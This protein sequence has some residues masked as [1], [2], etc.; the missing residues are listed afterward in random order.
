MDS[1][2]MNKV[3]GA[4]LG[5]C[6]FLVALNI[7]AGAVFTPVKMAKPGYEIAVPDHKPGGPQT[8]PAPT[9]QPIEPLLASADIARGEDS[10]KKCAA[11]H[12]FTKGG[13]KLVGPNLWGVMGRAKAALADFNYS[14][15]LKGKGGNWT[16]QDLN[17][18]IAN[19]RGAVPGTAMTFSGVARPSERADI[20]AY[21][22]SLS[23]SPAPLPRAALAPGGSAAQ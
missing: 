20:I 3:L 10:A 2:E 7:A 9:D 1:F 21:L 15:A 11:C 6:L 23:D 19:P 17:Q 18:F 4:V 12:T 5:T 8:A 14:P 13:Q 22:N 16:V